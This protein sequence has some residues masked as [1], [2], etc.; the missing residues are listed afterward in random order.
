M[1]ENQDEIE[2]DDFSKNSNI[3]IILEILINGLMTN[4]KN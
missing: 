3:F 2:W 1:R 4:K